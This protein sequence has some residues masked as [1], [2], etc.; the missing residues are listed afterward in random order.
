M[1][2]K[3]RPRPSG[4]CRRCGRW[5]Q[6]RDA[7]NHP[8]CS[9][10]T[11]CDAFATRDQ[12]PT[13]AAMTPDA[14]RMRDLQRANERVGA[15]IDQRVAWLLRFATEDPADLSVG[16]RMNRWE[17]L[18]AFALERPRG[19]GG[20]R[21]LSG[22]GAEITHDDR[23]MTAIAQA[24][25][26]GLERLL[27]EP[28]QPW[29]LP[30]VPARVTRIRR[31]GDDEHRLRF[32]LHRAGDDLRKAVMYEAAALLEACERLRRCP[33]CKAPFVAVRRQRRHPKCAQRA[34][35]RERQKKLKEERRKARAA[36]GR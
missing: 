30:I 21:P 29:T 25:R 10:Q 32:S 18:V 5:T 6:D 27:A 31:D 33:E 9:D 17:E 4:K 24:V 26:D 15:T 19:L 3:P 2:P 1:K 23:V 16:D 12:A 22:V 11:E 20:A 14:Q 36:R 13:R 7:E 35:E 8:R 34:H 28:P